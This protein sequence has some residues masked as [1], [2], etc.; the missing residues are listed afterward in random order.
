[1]D[2]Y[3]FRT[4]QRFERALNQIFAGLNE[5]LYRDIIGNPIFFDEA[6]V[7]LK[8]SVRRRWKAD[9]D[10]SKT[11]LYERMEHLEFLRDVHRHRQRL[12]AVTQIDAAPGGSLGQTLA[13]PTPVR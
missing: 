3:S 6:P 2:D 5:H 4:L 9:L 11:A 1:M 12:V 7:E 10:F 8:L 13:W